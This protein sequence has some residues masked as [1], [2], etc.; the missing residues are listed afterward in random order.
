[1][2][3]ILNTETKNTI[4][5]A[6]IYLLYHIDWFNCIFP[7]FFFNKNIFFCLYYLYIFLKNLSNYNIQKIQMTELNDSLF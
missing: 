7:V 6:H 5:M 3:Q 1:M 2:F 4:N